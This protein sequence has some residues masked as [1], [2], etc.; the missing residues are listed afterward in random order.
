MEPRL[1]VLVVSPDA[2]SVVAAAL[3][4]RAIDARVEPLVFGTQDLPEFFDRSVQSR[5]PR[6]YDLVICGPRVCR[7]DWQGRLVRPRLMDNL[8]G[9][10]GPVKWYARGDWRSEDAS[11]VEHLIGSGNLLLSGPDELLAQLVRRR[12]FGEA[13]EYEGEL[14]RMVAGD[15][16]DNER[17]AWGDELLSIVHV[18]KGDRQR[19]GELVGMLVEK[20][21]DEALARHGEAAARKQ[22]QIH[23]YAESHAEDPLQMGPHRLVCV[24]V[25]GEMRVFWEEIG[26]RAR[27]ERESDLS[28]CFLEDRRAALLARE[29]GSRLN[30]RA[31]ARY[32]TDL[33]PDVTSVSPQRDVVPF[34]VDDPRG[35]SARKR[36]LIEVMSGGSHLLDD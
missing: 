10:G 21:R 32:V 14:T 30:I 4:G 12:F 6:G 35:A 31:W 5:L 16:T 28:L 20:R 1:A 9:F 15:L 2:D 27:A 17:S 3:V 23:A 8:R 34:V 13:D 24:T 26:A 29:P 22:E 25:G 33:M 11:A 18:L 19:L 36:E 7:R